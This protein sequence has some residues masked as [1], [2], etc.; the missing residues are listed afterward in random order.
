MENEVVHDPQPQTQAEA[1]EPVKPYPETAPAVVAPSNF[2]AGG[3]LNPS[4]NEDLHD[5]RGQPKKLAD[6]HGN[7][8]PITAAQPVGPRGANVPLEH[9]SEAQKAETAAAEE[10]RLQRGMASTDFVDSRGEK[11]G[12][13]KVEPQGFDTHGARIPDKI[14]DELVE[15]PPPMVGPR[16][17][18][19]PQDTYHGAKQPKK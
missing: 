6:E 10:K 16:G 2:R 19:A 17:Q 15:P 14:T 7:Y 4:L 12:E 1:V 3:P 18:G 11:Q 8:Q 5:S 13:F 9:L